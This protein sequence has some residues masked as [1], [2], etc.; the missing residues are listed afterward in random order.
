MRLRQALKLF[1]LRSLILH[2]AHEQVSEMASDSRF[3]NL[4][5]LLVEPSAVQARIIRAEC[6]EIGLRQ[7]EIVGTVGD[8]LDAMLRSAPD[9]TLSALYLPDGTGTELV[10][11]MRAE[12]RLAEVPFLLI[13]S[14]TRPQA[15]EPVRQSGACGILPKPF[16]AAQLSRAI[17]RTLDLLGTS[18]V[19]ENEFDLE[20]IRVLL[21]DD[22]P[23]AR[24]FIRRV[25]ENLGL[26]H[27]IEASN[28]REAAALLADTMVDLIVTDYNMPEMDGREFVEYVRTRSWQ[29][30]VPILMVT[31]ESSESRLA[32]VQ[33]AGVSGIC[34]KPF[35][36]ALLQQLLAGMLRQS[37]G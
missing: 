4:R 6:D 11:A 29:Q 30:E 34:D 21:V 7:V 14:E 20:S 16:T 2:D 1:R 19:L 33:E 8:A 35:E 3:Q 13:S 31:S 36:T 18:H 9:L 17:S 24:R 12:G 15:L 28:G 22:S 10:E 32:A 23:N 26:R 27:F 37:E 5:A 25:L